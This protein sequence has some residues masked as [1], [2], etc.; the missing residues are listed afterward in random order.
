M[1]DLYP[2]ATVYGEEENMRMHPLISLAVSFAMGVTVVGCRNNESQAE[3]PAFTTVAEG[4]GAIAGT[5]VVQIAS[6]EKLS[7]CNHHPYQTKP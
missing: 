5:K 1:V 2:S 7:G 3:D 6:A 4:Q